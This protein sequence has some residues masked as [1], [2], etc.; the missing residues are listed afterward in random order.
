MVYPGNG[1]DICPKNKTQ[2]SAF[3]PLTERDAYTRD[4]CRKCW[5]YTS[6]NILGIFHDIPCGI[7]DVV[8]SFNQGQAI[9]YPTIPSGFDGDKNEIHRNGRDYKEKHKYEYSTING[10]RN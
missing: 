7:F 3:H 5:R 1:A 9:T 4:K 10:R 6:E 2:L 8:L